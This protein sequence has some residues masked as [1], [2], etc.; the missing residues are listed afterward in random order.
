MHTEQEQGTIK[1]CRECHHLLYEA[2][3]MGSLKEGGEQIAQEHVKRLLAA[4]HVAETTAELIL[5]HAP[6]REQLAGTCAAICQQAA[7]SCEAKSNDRM[8]QAARAAHECAR[9]C[10][11]YQHEVRQ[12]AAA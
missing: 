7:A 8:Q 9:L 2:F 4:A 6:Q 3:L 1:A 11:D 10:I 5:L 12:M